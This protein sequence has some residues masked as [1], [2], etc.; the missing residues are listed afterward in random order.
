[1]A[2]RETMPV[3]VSRE[4]SARAEGLFAPGC[5]GDRRE[6]TPARRFDA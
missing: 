5:C 6:V 2:A 1:M 4:R 3:S